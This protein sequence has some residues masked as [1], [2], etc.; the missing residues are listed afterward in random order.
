MS[1]SRAGSRSPYVAQ[2]VRLGSLADITQARAELLARA[3][4]RYGVHGFTSPLLD[5]AVP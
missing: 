3:N 4:N 2:S 1:A 5:L